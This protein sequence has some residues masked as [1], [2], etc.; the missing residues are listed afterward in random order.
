MDDTS[1]DLAFG[2]MYILMIDLSPQDRPGLPSLPAL[3]PA[4]VPAMKDVGFEDDGKRVHVLRRGG[5][6][7]AYDGKPSEEV[8]RAIERGR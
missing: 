4:Y 3:P 6:L 5:E 1:V 7:S 2:K 8:R